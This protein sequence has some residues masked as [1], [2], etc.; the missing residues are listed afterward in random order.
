MHLWAWRRVMCNL[1][2]TRRAALLRSFT[3]ASGLYAVQVSKQIK[4]PLRKGFL[5]GGFL[6]IAFWWQNAVSAQGSISLQFGNV[7]HHRFAEAVYMH[8][9]PVAYAVAV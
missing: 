4:P 9:I 5:S 1:P 6:L 2:Y 8:P 3:A 7:I